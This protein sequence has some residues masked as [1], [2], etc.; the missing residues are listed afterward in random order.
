M[1]VSITSTTFSPS[2]DGVGHVFTAVITISNTDVFNGYVTLCLLQPPSFTTYLTYASTPYYDIP[3]GSSEIHLTGVVAKLNTQGSNVIRSSVEKS[4]SGVVTTVAED[5]T[6]TVVI[7]A[8][9]GVAPVTGV[10]MT[11]M[12]TAIMP[13]FFLMMIMGMM[14]GFSTPSGQKKLAN[15]E[16]KGAKALVGAVKGGASKVKELIEEHRS[17]GTLTPVAPGP[18]GSEDSY[19]QELESLQDNLS[20][21]I[22]DQETYK[23]A[24]N[25]VLR[26]RRQARL[27]EQGV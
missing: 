15:L 26:R 6:G 1:G 23:Q 20:A 16:R 17:T 7:D 11:G 4:V 2:P 21:G 12:I 8:T 9:S 25:D 3:V 10:D 19:Q 5:R 24:V 18:A 13:L 27:S 22:I 14:K